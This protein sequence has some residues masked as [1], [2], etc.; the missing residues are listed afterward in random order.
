MSETSILLKLKILRIVKIGQNFKIVENKCAETTTKTSGNVKYVR[1]EEK[2]AKH[3]KVV[4][5]VRNTK[6]IRKCEV[7]QNSKNSQRY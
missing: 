1:F 6:I 2:T 7:C 3:V 4:N 5:T